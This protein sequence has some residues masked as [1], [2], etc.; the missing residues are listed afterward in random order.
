MFTLNN[1]IQLEQLDKYML[2]NKNLYIYEN[3]EE[4]KNQDNINN[5]IKNVVKDKKNIKKVKHSELY[6]KY[7]N[8]YNGSFYKNKQYDNIFW[9]FYDILCE[10]NTDDYFLNINN[11]NNNNI[12]KNEKDFKLKFIDKLRN[13]KSLLKQNSLRLINLE[14]EFSSDDK[15]SLDGLNSLCILYNLPFILAKDNNTYYRFNFSL[16]DIEDLMVDNNFKDINI[17]WFKNGKYSLEQDVTVEMINNIIKDYY[18][19]KN[20]NKPLQSIS[21]YKVEHLVDIANYLNIDVY[22]DKDK[23]KFKKKQELYETIYKKIY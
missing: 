16:L 11:N 23:I 2:I 1:N 15:I 14:G 10:K 20:Y 7:N 13:N 21:S 22:K 17:I 19:I 4:I 3:K 12:L 8:K 5:N 6:C 18:Y 9:C